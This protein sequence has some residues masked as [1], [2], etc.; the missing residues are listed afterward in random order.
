MKTVIENRLRLLLAQN[1]LRTDFQTHYEKIIA[2]YNA[3]K[4]RVIIE[5]TFEAL[6]KCVEELDREDSRA[7]REDLDAS[8]WPCSTCSRRT[9]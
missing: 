7:F 9:T 2:T 6:I 8:P 4:D 5:T 3:E 1:P